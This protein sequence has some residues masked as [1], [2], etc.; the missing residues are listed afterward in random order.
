M[1]INVSNRNMPGKWIPVLSMFPV[2]IHPFP[3]ALAPSMCNVSPLL[4]RTIFDPSKLFSLLSFS[5]L[6]LYSHTCLFI[7]FYFSSHRDKQDKQHVT[8][9][10]TSYLRCNNTILLAQAPIVVKVLSSVTP[11]PRL[12]GV[13]KL[14]WCRLTGRIG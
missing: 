1:C 4:S 10:G 2:C 12:L 8:I 13:D 11:H 6:Q 7:S 14:L 5:C 9:E 3:E